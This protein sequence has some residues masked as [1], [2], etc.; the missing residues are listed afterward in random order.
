METPESLSVWIWPLFASLSF[1]ALVVV[2]YRLIIQR[3]RINRLQTVMKYNWTGYIEALSDTFRRLKSLRAVLAGSRCQQRQ[4][5]ERGPSDVVG[6][7]DF[8][9]G[10]LQLDLPKQGAQEQ[11]GSIGPPLEVY[12]SGDV[13]L[14]AS[15]TRA[16]AAMPT[17]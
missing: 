1:L 11:S 6:S 13:A 17:R 9:P 5:V 3:V 2:V 14:R 4:G 16:I 8:P 12:S 10:R 7:P 15:G